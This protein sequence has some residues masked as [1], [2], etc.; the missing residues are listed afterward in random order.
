MAVTYDATEWA[1]LAAGG[2]PITAA[3]LNRM[4][5]GIADTAALA[6]KNETAAKAG[7]DL[8]AE[9]FGL[10]DRDLE[11]ASSSAA[12]NDIIGGLHFRSSPSGR[13]IECYGS[14]FM[15]FTSNSGL[16]N[17]YKLFRVTGTHTTSRAQGLQ[18]G[19]MIALEGTR[20]DV[21]AKY[22]TP[23]MADFD[24]S[25]N[26]DLWADMSSAPAYFDMS[27]YLDFGPHP[28]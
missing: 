5:A 4:E 23:L 7:A 24:G 9:F 28:L 10:A 27:V 6:N 17:K 26:V 25:G 16:A 11:K 19:F 21:S 15:T 18:V 22:I 14:G 12:T 1:D 13:I 3:Q 8:A 20:P 2:T